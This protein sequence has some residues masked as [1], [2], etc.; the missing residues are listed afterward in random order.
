[1][2]AVIIVCSKYPL[3]YG[4]YLLSVYCS[5]PFTDQ[6]TEVQWIA[7]GYSALSVWASTWMAFQERNGLFFKAHHQL[8]DPGFWLSGGYSACCVESWLQSESCHMGQCGAGWG[9]MHTVTQQAVA[10]GVGAVGQ[11]LVGLSPC[12]LFSSPQ[13]LHTD[14]QTY[15]ELFMV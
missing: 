11:Y 9:G 14:I 2:L 7:E 12:L 15:L 1:M 13:S 6:E 3:I 10:S 8:L 5:L 4:F